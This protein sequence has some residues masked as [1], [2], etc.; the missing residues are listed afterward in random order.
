MVAVHTVFTLVTNNGVFCIFT[1]KAVRSVFFFLA[2]AS[3][4]DGS[5]CGR[6]GGF[7]ILLEQMLFL[8]KA[9]LFFLYYVLCIDFCFFFNCLQESDFFMLLQQRLNH[10]FAVISVMLN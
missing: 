9:G 1:L 6:F 3:K 8:V 2:K 4:A 7:F 5:C 10:W